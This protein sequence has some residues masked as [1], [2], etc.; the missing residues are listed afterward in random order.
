MATD[1]SPELE[2]AIKTNFNTAAASD[3]KIR[4]I[5]KKARAGKA[6]QEDITV[7]TE[8][9]G[10]HASNALKSVLT[11]EN[12]PNGTLYYNIAEKTIK[13]LL[14]DNYERINN[15]AIVQQASEDK[16]LGINIGIV[17]GGYPENRV[18]QVIDF[19]TNAG[20]GKPLE[21]ALSDPV[22]SAHRKYYD[23]FLKENAMRRS[24]LGLYAVVTRIYDGKGLKKGTQECQ[25]CINRSGTWAYNDATRYGVFER[26][27]G[28]GC[29]ITYT[30]E[31]GHQIQTNWT[32]NTW[33]DIGQ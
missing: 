29:T 7:Y 14:L 19:A 10:I 3:A 26:H 21:N 27:V 22:V 8:R 15:I 20:T 2:K 18:N 5:I 33:T 31:K 16:T 23:D 9:L 4:S 6:T 12:L 11:P 24:R 25:W 30:T 32:D 17:K 13:P 1:I 28:C